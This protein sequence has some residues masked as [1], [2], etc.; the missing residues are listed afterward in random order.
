MSGI[1]MEANGRFGQALVA[2]L[3]KQGLNLRDL[4]MRVEAS[5]EHMRKLVKGMTPPSKPLLKLICK[6][7]KLDYQEMLQIVEEDRIQK[8]YGD[9][10]YK[11]VGKDPSI[12]VVEAAGLRELSKDEVK[13]V[14]NF[15]QSLAKGRRKA[16]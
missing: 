5:Y 10:V 12:G 1:L 9:A 8:K 7:I 11:M 4:A 13:M 6:E 2:E 16:K 15:I 3:D 14:A